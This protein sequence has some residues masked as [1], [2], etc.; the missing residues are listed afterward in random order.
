LPAGQAPELDLLFHQCLAAKSA[1]EGHES[2]I[3]ACDADPQPAFCRS[4]GGRSAGSLLG[5]T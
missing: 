4:G 5:L 3:V 1:M 2:F